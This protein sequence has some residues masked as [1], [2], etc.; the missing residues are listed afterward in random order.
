L[1]EIEV[2]PDQLARSL[3][4]AYRRLAQKVDVPGFRKGKTPRNMLERHVGRDRLV[5]EAIDILIPEAYNKAIEDGDIDAISQPDIELVKDEPLS[6]KATV[7]IRPDVDLGDYKSLRVE[8]PTPKVES[9]DVDA[10]VD[11]LRRRYALHE[12]VERAVATGDFVTAEVR[13]VIDGREVFKDDD[14]EFQLRDGA[15]LMLPGFREG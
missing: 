12:P 4:K 10:A 7:A 11:D 5:R 8:K 2:D 15:T 6:F 9:K 3:D 13:V 1:L 14:A